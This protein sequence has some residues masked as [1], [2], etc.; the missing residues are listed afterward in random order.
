VASTH[1]KIPSSIVGVP[2]FYIE[3][4]V[5]RDVIIKCMGNGTLKDATRNVPE[6]ESAYP[7]NRMFGNSLPAYGLYVRHA[8]N[9]KIENFQLKLLNP[10]FRSAVWLVDAKGI[11]FNDFQADMPIGNSPLIHKLNSEIKLSK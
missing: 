7:E 3:N 8:K 2:G 5:I 1:S 11:R 6:N 10:D 9:I 4:V